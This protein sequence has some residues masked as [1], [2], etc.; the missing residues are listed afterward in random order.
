VDETEHK[1]IP[2]WDIMALTQRPELVPLLLAATLTGLAVG[3]FWFPEEWSTVQ[4]VAGG[5]LLGFGSWFILYVNRM[6]GG[7]DFN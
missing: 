7:A 4:R 2:S 3:W 1:P 5:L 6:I